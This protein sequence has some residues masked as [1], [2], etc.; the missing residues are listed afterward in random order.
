MKNVQA[1]QESCRKDQVFTSE[2][3]YHFIG[4]LYQLMFDLNQ[5]YLVNPPYLN[6]HI[7][8]LSDLEEEVKSPHN[9][10]EAEHKVYFSM[11]NNKHDAKFKH[12]ALF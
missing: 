4:Y 12:L 5:C 2:F 1:F 3:K 9:L 11:E 6:A 8:N 10:P 7:S